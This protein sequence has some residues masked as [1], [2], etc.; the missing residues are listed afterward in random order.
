MRVRSRIA[1]YRLVN[2]G[3]LHYRYLRLDITPGLG[4]KMRIG[5]YLLR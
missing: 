2:A 3:I 5:D 1:Q 4:E